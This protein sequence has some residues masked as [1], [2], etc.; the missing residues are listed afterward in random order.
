[1]LAFLAIAIICPAIVYLNYVTLP[2]VFPKW[3]RPHPVTQVLILLVTLT[4]I[5]MALGYLYLNGASQLG[6]LILG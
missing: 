6:A 3:I 5:V 2:R 1:V 4:Y